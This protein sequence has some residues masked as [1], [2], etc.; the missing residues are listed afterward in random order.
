ML[1]SDRVI[2]ATRSLYLFISQNERFCNRL[3]V[4]SE[5]GMPLGLSDRELG[6][7]TDDKQSDRK[8]LRIRKARG[9]FG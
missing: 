6:S 8:E 9:A 2:G 5:I 4:T 1:H 3:V 7:L